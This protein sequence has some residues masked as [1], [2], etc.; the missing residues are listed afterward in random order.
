MKSRFQNVLWALKLWAQIFFFLTFFNLFS[1][2]GMQENSACVFNKWAVNHF[3]SKKIK[4]ML[5]Q[6]FFPELIKMLTHLMESTLKGL[7]VVTE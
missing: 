1:F 4:S 5:E 2:L 3:P 6:I 7:L